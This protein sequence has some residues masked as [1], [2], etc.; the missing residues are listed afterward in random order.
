MS[1]VKRLNDECQKDYYSQLPGFLS[2]T[3]MKPINL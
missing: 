3:Y 2:S 1:A